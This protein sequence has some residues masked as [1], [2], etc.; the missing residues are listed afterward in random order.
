MF[1]RIGYMA[2]PMKTLLGWIAAGLA[3][4]AAAGASAGA[5]AA[6]SG[7]TAAPESRVRLVSGVDATGVDGAA[8][9]GLEIVLKD[10]W[11]TYWRA[12]GPQGYPPRLD[13]SASKNVEKAEIV[14]PA[15]KRFTVLGY[16]SIG[17]AE[18]VTLPV[19]VTFKDP[20]K[21]AELRVELDY[22][23]CAEICV[24]QFASLSLNLPGGAA[25]PTDHAFAID[26][27]RGKAPA[28]DGAGDRVLKAWLEGSADQPSLGL[29]VESAASPATADVF[30]DGLDG[31]FFSAPTVSASGDGR[32]VLKA[33]AREVPPDAAPA[34]RQATYT[35]L[36]DGRAI[37]ARL[38]LSADAPTGV[39]VEAAPASGLLWMLLIAFLGGL[40]LNVMPCVLPVLAIKL[41]GALE[42]AER[43]RRHVRIGFAASAAGIVVSFLALAAGAIALKSAGAAV[44]WGIQFQ[45]PL[46]VAGMAMVMALFAANLWGLFE[47]SAL[48]AVNRAGAALPAETAG[49]TGPFWTGVLATALATPCSAP[50]VGSALTFALTRGSGE[51]LAIFLAMGVGLAAPY[52][53]TAAAP[54]LARLLPRPGAWMGI[55]R[56]VMA[57]AVALTGVWLLWILWRQA[58]EGALIAGALGALALVAA[59]RALDGVRRWGPAIAVAVAGLAAVGVLVAPPARQAPDGLEWARFSE[60]ELARRVAGGET[61]LVDVTADWCVTCKWNKAAVLTQTPIK[62]RLAGDV[63]PMQADW[64]RH[65]PEIASYLAKFRRFGIP[66]NAVYGPAAPE[67]VALPELLTAEEV[68]AA[69]ARAQGKSG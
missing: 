39:S 55:L 12:P 40:I 1:R 10:G 27:A 22:L 26:R 63:M 45:Q 38:P 44:G 28:P 49:W 18:A 6:D 16:D 65:D 41:M 47:F 5:S 32:D 61:V 56:R 58:G 42:H 13:W 52:L 35:L 34:A 68:E 2:W 64:T 48:A 14:W 15:P 17:Y 51:I 62:E 23:T 66:F 7:W 46:F 19:Q 69:I 37:E 9:M 4:L 54:G 36:L 33:A 57:A 25:G 67:G 60:A 21:P 20:G 53:L 29:E 8:P 24:P 59:F 31:Y 50:F 43:G 30:V 11:K 3:A